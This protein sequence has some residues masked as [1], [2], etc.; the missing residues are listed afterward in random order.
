MKSVFLILFFAFGFVLL[1]AQSKIAVEV[2]SLNGGEL[3]AKLNYKK[4][5]LLVGEA[6]VEVSRMLKSLHGLGFIEASVDS[7][8]TDD[9]TKYVSF[10][11][12][13]RQYT[14]SYLKSGNLPTEVL[15][16]TKFRQSDFDGRPFSF[17][18]VND[19]LRKIISY[20]ENHGYPF[21]EVR[22]DSFEI[23][24][25]LIFSNVYIEPNELIL[26]DSVVIHGN[27][28]TK[29]RFLQNY[30]QIFVGDLYDESKVSSINRK[31]GQLPYLSMSKNVEVVFTPGLAS[32]HVYLQKQRANQFNFILGVLP[33]NQLSDRKLTIT[34]DGRLHLQNSF[35]VGEEIFAEFKQIKPQTQNLNL[36]FRYPYI[37]NLPIGT[38]GAFN[39]YKNDTL[40]VNLDA[41]LGLFYQFSGINHFKAFFHNQTSNV[42]NYDTARIKLLEEL[43]QTIDVSNNRYGV[44]LFFQNL[45]YVLNPRKGYLMSISS[46]VGNKTIKKNNSIVSL[47]GS[48]GESLEKLYNGLNLKSITY[49]IDFRLSYFF[50]LKKRSTVVFLN[51]SRAIIAKNIFQNEMYRIG[52]SRLLRGFDEES[53]FTPFY[54]LSTIEYRFLLS[55]NSYFNTF[56]D[57]AVVEDSRLNS[58]AVDLPIGFG[59]GLALE[60][61]GG[62][63]SLSYALGK[64]FDNKIEIRNGKI[65]FGYITLF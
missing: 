31:I 50:P 65:H 13:G 38:D 22:L 37:A 34:G 9:S 57:F 58:G 15:Q 49:G 23:N 44:E 60:T 25:D 59:T 51:E 24:G 46:S 35:G 48:D 30:L 63:F 40:F 27:S 62:I 29:S 16:K 64:Q 17:N 26:I 33:N 55:K 21:A 14:L 19:Q 5:V 8:F 2:V 47:E 3:P 39:L 18:E 43:P 10:L 6:E 56:F 41:E 61:K 4:Y 54:A 45:D 53:I 7:V 12:L 42:L 11:Y 28:G 1:Q 36:N 52:G 32:I 20:Y